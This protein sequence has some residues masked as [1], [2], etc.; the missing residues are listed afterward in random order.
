MKLR[1]PQPVLSDAIQGWRWDDAAERARCAEGAVV[2]HDEK[3][4][5]RVLGR[6]DARRPPR[7]RLGGFLLD[8]TTELRIRRRQLFAVN[9]CRGAGGTQL[10]GD[11]L[12]RERT[13]RRQKNA[14]EDSVEENLSS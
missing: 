7:F 10:T 13:R 4:V 2:G 9:G 8:H 11:L 3:D 6:D 5:G 12:G 14:G 1:I